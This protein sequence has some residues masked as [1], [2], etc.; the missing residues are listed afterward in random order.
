MG[1]APLS[2]ASRVDDSDTQSTNTLLRDDDKRVIHVYNRAEKIIVQHN[3]YHNALDLITRLRKFD[4]N[5]T[6][7]FN[8][9]SRS[10]LRNCTKNPYLQVQR[11]S[12]LML[13]MHNHYNIPPDGFTEWIINLPDDQI[14]AY[15]YFVLC[16]LTGGNPRFLFWYNSTIGNRMMKVAR[17]YNG[18]LKNMCCDIL[19]DIIPDNDFRLEL[20]E[21]YPYIYE[22]ILIYVPATPSE[23]QSNDS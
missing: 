10:M 3:S 20:M 9:V 4:G 6:E 19:N 23:P 11:C 5:V 16:Q 18:E 13:Y 12:I 22:I 17:L 8:A 1:N 14:M 21:E 2:D 15:L 7:F